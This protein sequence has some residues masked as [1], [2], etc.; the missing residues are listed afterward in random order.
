MTSTLSPPLVSIVMPVLDEA[1]GIGAALARLQPLRGR[2]CEVI[3][4][5]GGSRDATVALAT[6][7]CDRVAVSPPGRAAQMNAGARLAGGDA[8]LFLHAD[9]ELPDDADRLVH[10]AL[11]GTRHVWGRFDVC[12]AGR[13]AM[14]RVIAA[15]MNLRSRITAV[16]TGDQ[17]IFCRRAAFDAVGGFPSQPLMEDVEISKRLRRLGPPACLRARVTTSGRRW[18]KHGVARTVLL[19]WRL[20]LAY[21]LGVDPARLVRRYPRHRD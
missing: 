7:A 19:M 12:I 10:Q 20:R 11:A 15:T 8:L 21:F 3:V 2:G 14:L 6:P 16:A 4:V 17:A 18:E 13:P 9:T 1:A 5:D